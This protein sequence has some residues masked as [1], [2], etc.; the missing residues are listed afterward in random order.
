[1]FMDQA[2][3]RGSSQRDDPRTLQRVLGVRARRH[4]AIQRRLQG[5]TGRADLFETRSKCAPCAGTGEP[6]WSPCLLLV[7]LHT[8]TCPATQ[9]PTQTPAFCFDRQPNRCQYGGNC[10]SRSSKSQHPVLTCPQ[11][12]VFW[13]HLDYVGRRSASASGEGDGLRVAG[14]GGGHP[15]DPTPVAENG[16]LDHEL[17][18]AA[19][20]YR[21]E[22][23]PTPTKNR[24]IA[25]KPGWRDPDSNRGHHGFQWWGNL[26]D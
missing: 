10:I 15:G 12:R 3:R 1:M 2:G 8:A 17:G 13:R 23:R 4:V 6:T 20:N 16:V 26:P 7:H 5:N 22:A 18:H 19:Q 21:C 14:V 25:R 11:L 9:E 24:E